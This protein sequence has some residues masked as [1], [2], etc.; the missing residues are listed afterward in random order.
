M[1][2][3]LIHDTLQ[4]TFPL[5]DAVINEAPWQCASLQH[6]RLLQLINGVKL[7]AVVDSLL[8]GPKWRNP[9]DLN[10]GCQGTHVWL[11]AGDILT[12]QVRDNVSRNVRWR[13]ILLQSSL[14]APSSVLRFH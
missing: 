4:T 2:A 9:P 12:P 8:H 14:V 3:I 1:S 11:N 7:P 5:S 10:P 13:T 6:N